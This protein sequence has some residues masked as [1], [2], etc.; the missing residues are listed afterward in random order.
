MATNAY[1]CMLIFDPNKYAQDQSGVSGAVNELITKNGGQVLVSRLFN[2]QKL[3]YPIGH[4]RKGTYW[5]IYFKLDGSKLAVAGQRIDLVYRRV[6]MNDILAQPDR[7]M[8]GQHDDHRAEP[9]AA[10]PGGEP[11]QEIQ[12]VGANLIGIEMMLDAPQRVEAH[13]LDLA[14]QPALDVGL[15]EGA[16][17]GDGDAEAHQP[18]RM[19][20]SSPGPLPL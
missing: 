20:L 8:P 4:H 12:R 19:M 10:G 2:E 15:D 7:I 1:E 9:D 18:G 17:L 6:L 13:G 5:L 16:G 3:A 11:G 14:G